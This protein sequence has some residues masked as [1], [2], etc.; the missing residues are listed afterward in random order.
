MTAQGTLSVFPIPS[1]DQMNVSIEG[2]QDVQVSI[3]LSDMTGKAVYTET[4]V[5]TSNQATYQVLVTGF[6]PGVYMVTAVGMEKSYSQ[7]VIIE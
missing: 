6:T 3:T 5:P 2:S 4:V 7:K 1:V